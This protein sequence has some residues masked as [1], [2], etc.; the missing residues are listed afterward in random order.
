MRCCRLKV[1]QVTYQLNKT[2]VVVGLMGAGKTAVGTLVAQ[3]LGV[4]FLD[5]DQEI[6]KAANM[7]VAEI[8]ERDGEAFFRSKE[9]Q[10]LER[11]LQGDPCILST[12]GGAY[13]SD[14]NRK[15]ISKYGVALWLRADLDLLWNRV[16]HK[17][18]RPL[19]R[20]ENPYQTLADL[21]HARNPVYA[22][23]KIAVDAEPG[24]SLDRMAGKVVSALL[25]EPQSGVKKEDER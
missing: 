20:T 15:L 17:D 22:K 8:F 3:K 2:I 16:K 24:L 1:G 23:A 11:L 21:Y 12:G 7:S 9:T 14:E 5:S 19:L 25:N 6:V 10:V 4:P 18:T 13:M